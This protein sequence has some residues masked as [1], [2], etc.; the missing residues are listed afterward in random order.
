[1]KPRYLILIVSAVGC[2]LTAAIYLAPDHILPPLA[3]SLDVGDRPR[4]VDYL[5]VLGGDREV[6]P[7]VAAALYKARLANRV[8]VPRV[9]PT[10]DV[11]AGILPSE[12]ERVKRVLVY[13]GV[14]AEDVIPL[15]QRIESTHD[16]ARLPSSLAPNR[17]L[18]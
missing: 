10:P 2:C 8:L 6:R 9:R 12:D 1:M 4:A 15:G 17:L 3:G 13:R 11:E 14:R 18:G 16:E 5:F 7:L